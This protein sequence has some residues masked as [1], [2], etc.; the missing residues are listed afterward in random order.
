MSD[1]KIA[2]TTPGAISGVAV[3]NSN[4]VATTVGNGGSV[5]VTL[6][7]VGP[8]S[9]TVVS[10]TLQIGKVTTLTAGSS[11]TVVNSGSA[12][13]AVL[14]IGLPAGK[15]GA[16]GSAGATGPAGPAGATG[17]TGA[18]GA[19]GSTGPA[20]KDGVTPS[21]SVS[22]VTTGDPGTSAAVTATTTN[23]GANVA[24]AFTIPRGAT[25]AAGSG[26]GSSVSLSDATPQPAG[27]ASAGTSS[28]AARGDHVHAIPTISY[29]NLTNVPLAFAPSAHVHGIGDVTG[30]QTALN[31]KQ[32]SGSYATLTSGLVQSS[33]LPLATTS[34]AGA[35]IVGTGLSISSGVLS[36][37]GGGITANDTVDGGDY[38]G[39]VG[40]TAGA[41]TG[42]A[43]TANSTSVALSWTAPTSNGGTSIIDYTV[44][45]STDSGTSW[46]TFAHSASTSTSAT[47]TNLTRG[48]AYLFR[49]AAVNALGNGTFSS[50]SASITPAI[51]APGQV[52]NLVATSGVDVISLSWNAPT[53]NGGDAASY[54]VQSSTDGGTTWN[55]AKTVSGTS[56]TLTGYDSGTE[57]IFRVAATN[58]AGT[59]SY[60]SASSSVTYRTQLYIILGSNANGFATVGSYGNIANVAG[61]VARL[62]SGQ[63]QQFRSFSGTLTTQVAGTLSIQMTVSGA[64]NYGGVDLP[65]PL[66][67]NGEGSYNAYVSVTA[68]QSFAIYGNVFANTQSNSSITILATIS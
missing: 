60:S 1:I 48:T 27:T 6:G 8:S 36:A 31:G 34:A 2:V 65:T 52:T 4:T 53:D 7:T 64:Q 38:A 47:V 50:A 30:L 19:T 33:V 43:G 58:S 67:G 54:I 51:T 61:T 16:T 66:Y 22:S 23:S 35:I 26:G 12:Y 41:P 40:T 14:D 28:S 45:Y 9:P 21:F 25:G 46:T 63:S 17:A 55:T 44:Q 5:A 37:T 49:V 42:V 11:A 68:G 18:A 3:S 56:T 39:I 20:G 62:Q 57:F 13:A 10:G 24:L 15:D 29:A 59:G 32:A